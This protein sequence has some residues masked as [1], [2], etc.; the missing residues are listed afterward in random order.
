MKEMRESVFLDFLGN[1]PTARVL[2][3]LITGRE[4]DYSLTDIAEKSEIGWTTLHRILPSLKKMEI[5][6]PTR[7]VGR[8]RLYKLN[9]KNENVKKL[10]ELYDSLLK[11]ELGKA[12]EESR[13]KAVAIEKT[14]KRTKN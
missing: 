14:R 10:I 9:Q 12:E 2:D 1:S 5:L 13:V 8:A 3:F 11:R 4:F 7:A 6:V